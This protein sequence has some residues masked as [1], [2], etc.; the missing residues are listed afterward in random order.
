MPAL[1]AFDDNQRAP[2]LQLPAPLRLPARR[3]TA[4][5]TMPDLDIATADDIL[6]LAANALRITEYADAVADSPPHLTAILRQIERLDC[7]LTVRDE[8]IAEL[9]GGTTLLG[10]QLAVAQG[11]G[12]SLSKEVEM[13]RGL[14]A[15]EQEAH[16]RTLKLLEAARLQCDAETGE[17]NRLAELHARVSAEN[18]TLLRQLSGHITARFECLTLTVTGRSYAETAEKLRREL[19]DHFDTSDVQL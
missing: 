15:V 1:P 16:A 6:D 13:F 7:D 2:T 8:R 3:A 12:S 17:R 14:L 4:P 5:T 19:D 9:I 11:V 18:A 10:Q